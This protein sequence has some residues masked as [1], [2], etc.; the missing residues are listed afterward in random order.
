METASNRSCF[1]RNCA[2]IPLILSFSLGVL[3]LWT[4]TSTY[5]DGSSKT[6]QS[7]ERKPEDEQSQECA[8]NEDLEEPPLVITTPSFKR[9]G[10][11]TEKSI[12]R[13]K[14]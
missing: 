9:N 12:Q 1:S 3:G 6:V 13:N 11:Y 4:G 5:D 10:I 7:V 14:L 2:Q 8:Q